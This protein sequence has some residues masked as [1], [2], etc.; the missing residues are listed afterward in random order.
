M[1]ESNI[2]FICYEVKDNI[3]SLPHVDSTLD[4]SEHKI[5]HDCYKI[6]TNNKCPFCRCDIKLFNAS[7]NTNNVIRTDLAGNFYLTNI[8]NNFHR[9]VNEERQRDAVDLLMHDYRRRHNIISNERFRR[10]IYGIETP[11]NRK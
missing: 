7:N 10:T 9:L 5:C 2:C 4:V 11:L 6:M 1:E 3:I 8:F